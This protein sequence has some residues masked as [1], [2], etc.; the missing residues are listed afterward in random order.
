MSPI[1]GKMERQLASRLAGIQAE[2]YG[3]GPAAAKAFLC[4]EEVAVVV[5]EETFTP[6]EKLLIEHGSR[7]EVQATRRKFQQINRDQFSSVVEQTTGRIVDTF[8][9]ETNVE[10]D[11]SVEVFLLGGFRQDMAEL[12]ADYAEATAPDPQKA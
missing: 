5:L 6:A 11:V 12:E 2:Y 8:L 10:H 7:D 3:R 1:T 4:G 9:S